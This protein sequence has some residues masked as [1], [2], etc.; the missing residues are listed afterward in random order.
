MTV[1]YRILVEGKQHTVVLSD[2]TQALLAAKAAGRAFVGVGRAGE[3]LP[4]GEVPYVIPSF[5]DASEELA[6]LVLLRSLGLPW[7]IAETP[8][9][10]LRELVRED[11]DRIPAG[12][13]SQEERVFCSRELLGTYCLRQYRFY[14]YG[15]WAVVEKRTGALAGIAGVSN[16][17][18]PAALEQQLARCAAGH[19]WLELGY[20]IFRPFRRQR[21]G[22]E[23]AGA[24][25]DY[26]REV[27]GVNLCALIHAN[28]KASRS[29]AERLGFE[30][31]EAQAP[32]TL[33]TGEQTDT[34]WP[35]ALLLYVW[36]W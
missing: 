28:N 25:M 17:R 7:V 10:T 19:P 23:A 13:C 3:Q 31:W 15:T 33:M 26:S 2:E 32:E 29:L 14:E 20:H 21:Y 22:C 6:R 5:A 9:L 4:M 11:A 24:I 12:E 27:L 36:C 16:P 8:R 30:Q 35:S 1:E 34:L 18:L